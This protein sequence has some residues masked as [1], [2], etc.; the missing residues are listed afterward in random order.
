MFDLNRGR[1]RGSTFRV[2]L[3]IFRLY[4]QDCALLGIEHSF[5][6]FRRCEM[7]VSWKKSHDAVRRVGLQGGAL[8]EV[9][10]CSSVPAAAPRSSPAL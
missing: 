9:L 1:E 5:K 2:P 6:F 7:H 3:Q 4:A 10:A 8:M